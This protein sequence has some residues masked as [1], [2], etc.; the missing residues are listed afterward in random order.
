MEQHSSDIPQVP[1]AE[2][3]AFFDSALERALEAEERG[4]STRAHLEVGKTRV[5]LRFAGPRLPE[6][7]LPPLAHLELPI[8]REPD[9]VFH[10]GEAASTGIEMVPPPFPRQHLTYRG[11]IWG[12]GNGRVRIAFHWHDYSVN[13]FDEGSR[14]GIYWVN[15]AAQLPYWARASP[16]RTLFHWWMQMNGAQLLH[17]AAFGTDDDGGMLLTGRGGTGKST[18]SLTALFDGMLFAGDDYL[19]AGLDPEPTAY[20]LYS[21]AKLTPDQIRRFPALTDYLVPGQAPGDDKSV[22]QLWP[23]FREQ[24][25]R[26]LPLRAIATPTFADSETTTFAPGSAAALQR[27]VAFTTMSQL[28]HAGRGTQEFIQRLVEDVPGF[29]LRLG[30]DLAEVPRAI[31]RQL[32]LEDRALGDRARAKSTDEQ[33]R[34]LV[35]VIIPVYN[36]AHLIPDAVASILAQS[37]WPLEIIVVDDGSRDEIQE[38]VESLPAEVRFVRQEN[39]GPAAA[40]NR[41][42]YEASG[43]LLAFLDADDL[44]TDD[45]LDAL[46][47]PLLADGTADVALG[48]SQVTTLGAD[49]EAGEF[50]GNPQE[51]FRFSIANG[52]YR[53]RGFERVGG[54]DPELRFG[55]D[56]DWFRRAEE[57]GLRVVQLD[58]VTMYVRRHANNSTRGKTLVELNTLRVLKKHIDRQREAALEPTAPIAGPTGGGDALAPG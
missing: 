55:E 20:S 25:K 17:A 16:L 14:R 24:L 51:T 8:D 28:P 1:E 38:A 48:R 21:S 57:A 3:L 53:R 41:G 12:M 2:Q 56:S 36:G 47:E 11:D 32:S 31:R 22:V 42:M 40:R 26:A 44:W 45:H 46:W 4:G 58:V 13:L 30:R 15:D 7:L 10:V 34:P 23:A 35:S 5:E 18:T 19:I 6:I 43:D 29:T 50:L 27:S 52:L 54:F 9:V 49:G 37:S 39:A 33:Q